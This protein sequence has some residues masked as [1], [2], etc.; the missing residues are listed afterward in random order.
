MKFSYISLK[1]KA[2]PPW[3]NH[4]VKTSKVVI[5]EPSA[6]AALKQ[7][8]E[9]NGPGKLKKWN[10][11]IPGQMTGKNDRLAVKDGALIGL[12]LDSAAIKGD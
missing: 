1:N 2:P 5:T 3:R 8:Y 9:T 6:V 4:V 12:N 7:I 11:S 10:F